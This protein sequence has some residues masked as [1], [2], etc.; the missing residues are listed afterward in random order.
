MGDLGLFY[1][2]VA[3]LAL[4]GA[5]VALIWTVVAVARW[6]RPRSRTPRTLLGMAAGLVAELLCLSAFYATLSLGMLAQLPR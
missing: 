6:L 5:V 2:I 3:L 1:D 4:A